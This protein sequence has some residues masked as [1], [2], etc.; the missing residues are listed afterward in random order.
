MDKFREFKRRGRTIVIVSHDL[1]TI[2]HLCDEVMWLVDGTSRGRGLPR[3][4]SDW[5]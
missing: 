2:E 5:W 3:Q 1:E 4:G